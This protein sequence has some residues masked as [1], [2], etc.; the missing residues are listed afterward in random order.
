MPYRKKIRIGIF[1]SSQSLIERVQR[2]AAGQ[3]DQI[4]INTQGL[5]DAIPLALEMVRNGVEIIISRRGT[6]HLLRE[7]LRIPVLSFPHRS[8]DI[9]VS[10]KQAA[11]LGRKILLP[12]FRH[13]LSGLETLE[14]L[15]RIDLIQK[16][17]QDKA[18]LEA[19]IVSG[20]REGCQVAIGGSVT[21]QM[22]DAHGM[23][24]IEIR[25]SD[26]DIA[27]TIEDAKSI[28]LTARDQ[29]ATALR[30]HAIIDAASDNIIAVDADGRITTLNATAAATLKCHPDEIVGRRITEV[31]PNAPI[32]LVLRNQQP[33]H[34]RLARI[35]K[36]RY[37]FNYRPVTLEGAVIGAVTTFRDIGNVM[38]SEHVVRRSLSRGLVAKYTLD[39]LVHVSPAMRDV[40]NIGRQYAGT[41]STI[42]IMGETG[43]GKEIFVHG[44]HSLSRRADQPFVSVN[45]AAL[46]EQ[47][48]ESELFGYEEGAFTGSK[49]G[50]KPG[51]FEIAHQGTIF[52]D[53]IDATPEA[54]QIRLLR[55][56]QEREVMRVGGG[57]KIPVDVRIVA[58]A[59]RDLSHAVQEGSFR[60]DL[61]FRLNV[62]RLQIP[63][64]RQ[65][66]E[67]IPLLLD[68]FIR[69]LSQ[70]HGL[71]PI[72]LP[73]AYLDR[74]MAYAWP[75][76]V[77][78][79]R[80]FAERLV[81]NCSLRCRPDT[82]EVL[83]RELIQYG[84][85]G[86]PQEKPKPPAAAL[87]DR[88][89]AQ[90]LD[91]ERAIILEALEQ[92]RYHKNRAARRLGISRTTLWRKIKELG[93][94]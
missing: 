91:N 1:A 69:L 2:L 44:I 11:D 71:E 63:P 18:S 16:I 52:L 8:L 22:A 73:D 80:N 82:L 56:L 27:A 7:N 90:T 45:C 40:V 86:A 42:L 57:R 32:D 84:T 50:G 25:T 15:L 89:K 43:T 78:Q 72:S 58:A 46:P 37:V 36:D 83:F 53:E 30:Y 65:R 35:D 81:M 54:V 88:M 3:P 41:E 21:K 31:I 85:H 94:D 12:V 38:R 28:A 47:L 29:K 62:L 24:F 60:A 67:D 55:I 79:M 17:Y 39:D 20:I 93:I 75:G 9:L 13:A 19:A 34:D 10:L 92:C 4:F 76:N 68:H 49:K 48:L 64:L 33:I 66:P 51:R 59:S 26:E 87:K 61:F 70:R 74:L 5:D 77:R 23:A 14:E 6:A